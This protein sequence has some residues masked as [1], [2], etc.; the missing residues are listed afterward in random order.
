MHTARLSIVALLATTGL[1]LSAAPSWAQPQT[2]D[3]T[4]LVTFDSTRSDPAAAA[5]QA[6]E[7]AGGTVTDVQ[8]LGSTIAAVTITTTSRR[9]AAAIEDRAE[10]Q[11]GV[12][13]A[14]VAGTVYPTKTDDSYYS[15]LWNLNNA[16]ASTYGV[17]AESAWA[18]STGAGTV[19]GIIDTGITRNTD[20]N[21][22]VIAG[23]DFIDDDTNPTDAGPVSATSWHGTHVAGIAAGIANN[24]VGTFGVAP[25]AKIEPIRMLGAYGGSDADLVSAI[26]W[27]AGVSKGGASVSN[28][29]PADVL[30]LSLGSSSSLNL[31]CPTALQTA[32]NQAV[33][34]G[35]TVVVAAGNDA[36]SLAATYPANCSNVI[37]VTATGV[38]GK[39]AGYSNHGTTA[40]P[41]TVA[42]PGGSAT[43]G[44]D[45]NPQH[46]IL[47]TWP[48]SYQFMVGTSMAAPHVAGEV[49]LLKSIAPSL[50]PAQVTAV[51]SGHTTALSDGCTTAR[52]GK[53]IVNAAAA[54][55]HLA[56][57]AVTTAK[58]AG[59]AR[60][61]RV[62]RASMPSSLDADHLSYQWLRDGAAIATATR[63]SYRLS[64]ADYRHAVSVRIT[65]TSSGVT[66]TKTSARVSVAKGT[67]GKQR[68]P[69]ARGTAR[70]GRTLTAFRGRWTQS[71]TSYRYQ[72]LRDGHKIAKA[73]KTHYRLTAK[74]RGH[75][76][77]IRITVKRSVYVT[78]SASSPQRFVR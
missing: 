14:E 32:I 29:H 39:L 4:I 8:R 78:R 47:S 16:S 36:T 43:S 18:T 51:I 45:P 74:D 42:A 3:Q 2:E 24:G 56:P 9:Q 5:E 12:K 34:A 68:S 33:A 19:I 6:V 66:V 35:T 76:I 60:V 40:F 1:L 73:T 67:F 20:L 26:L 50:T 10:D 53:G 27:G 48:D 57:P 46:W 77:S 69:K 13:A 23:Y 11:R 31:S 75:K 72:W 37:R 55:A 65:A 61:G 21:A 15:Y 22:H 38:D 7:R 59:T 52:C 54:V 41:A 62:V 70:V 49:A 30:N 63:S 17:K 64:K 44:S 71:P 58:V 28:A 25:N